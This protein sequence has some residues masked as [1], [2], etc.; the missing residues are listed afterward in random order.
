MPY[1]SMPDL[2]EILREAGL[3]DACL[4][5][6]HLSGLPTLPADAVER[7]KRSAVFMAAICDLMG[8][9]DPEAAFRD[10][11][12]ELQHAAVEYGVNW[13]DE[14]RMGWQ[15]VKG[16]RAKARCPVQLQGIGN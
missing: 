16:E 3:A 1:E 5:P 6:S 11:I 8:T 12:R 14:D 9:E 4:A 15:D 13:T 10:V 2:P 7:A